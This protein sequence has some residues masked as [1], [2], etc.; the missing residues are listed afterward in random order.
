MDPLDARIVVD[1]FLKDGSLTQLYDTVLAPALVMAE[2][3]R[4]RGGIDSVREEFL[5]LNINEMVTEFAEH[6]EDKQ[7][8]IG[9]NGRIL[10]IPANDQADEIAAAMLAQ[11]I[12]QRGCAAVSFPGGAELDEMLAPD[13][14]R[15][16]RSDL[17]LGGCSLTPS[18]PPETF[19]AASAR[20][21]PACR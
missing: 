20:T 3:D 18:R 4:H 1:A 9:F 6:A 16:G 13:G 12:E 10:C 17:H 7:A 15:A 21:F 5:F 19:A 14:S 2:Q 11:L 8:G